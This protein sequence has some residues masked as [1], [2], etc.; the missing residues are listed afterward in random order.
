[1]H[2]IAQNI[3]SDTIIKSQS[4]YEMPSEMPVQIQGCPWPPEHRMFTEGFGFGSRIFLASICCYLSRKNI[5][6]N[7]G[8]A[9]KGSQVEHTAS[10][11]CELGLKDPLYCDIQEMLRPS[12]SP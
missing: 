1:M 5:Q 7:M 8:P 11:L 6:I 4:R 10:P 2:K 9:E 3:N 12:I